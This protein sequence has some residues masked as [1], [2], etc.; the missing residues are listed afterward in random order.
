MT[1]DWFLWAT[2][3]ITLALGALAWAEIVREK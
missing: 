2:F 1:L 3:V